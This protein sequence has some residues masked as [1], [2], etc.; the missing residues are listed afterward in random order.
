M[1][2][3]ELL[4]TCLNCFKFKITKKKQ[5]QTKTPCWLNRHLS[6]RF[7]CLF[8]S[9][10]LA[11]QLDFFRHIILQQNAGRHHLPSVIC[12][13]TS[14]T[15]KFFNFLTKSLIQN[16]VHFTSCYLPGL[17]LQKISQLNVYSSKPT[18][19]SSFSVDCFSS[20]LWMKGFWLMNP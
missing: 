20:T 18:N 15:T 13:M 10:L 19:L 16:I 4:L 14:L 1:S 8:L 12:L 7:D 3:L 2:N 11:K 6:L 5:T 17:Y 9:P